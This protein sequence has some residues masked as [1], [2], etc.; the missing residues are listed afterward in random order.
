MCVSATGLCGI[1]YVIRA[2]WF[3]PDAL[4]RVLVHGDC[5]AERLVLHAAR[6]GNE[7][8]ALRAYLRDASFYALP[9]AFR[10]LVVLG[11]G[12]A[13][14]LVIDRIAPDLRGYVAGKVVEELED[15]TGQGFGFSRDEW[16]NWWHSVEDSW[17]LPGKR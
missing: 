12:D 7:C 1:A 3:G 6:H 8:E 11:D 9:N 16:K 14:P 5:G 13:V 17:Q 2:L 10:A 15:T 4:A